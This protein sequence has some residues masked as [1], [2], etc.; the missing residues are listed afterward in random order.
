M[1]G[2]PRPPA[3]R[4]VQLLLM[5]EGHRVTRVEAAG[6]VL[7]DAPPEQCRRA[8]SKA[9]SQ[10]REVLGA[11]AIVAEGAYLRLGG[12]VGTDLDEVRGGLR[13]AL[14]MGS[15]A[16]RRRLLE[17]E[18]ERVSP[19]LPGE[20]DAD[21]VGSPRRQLGELVRAGRVAL[22]EEI[23]SASGS[24]EGWESA[25]EVDRSDEEVAV[26]LIGALRRTGADARAVQVYRACR[27]E[28]T[29]HAGA[30]PSAQLQDAVR[31]L[32]PVA[33]EPMGVGGGLL[34][35]DA[36]MKSMLGWLRGAE[37]HAGGA[38]L[39]SGLAGIGKTAILEAVSASLRQQGW[40]VGWA[41]AGAGDELVPYSALR[42]ALADVLGSAPSGV[43]VP[44]SI[45]AL[46]RTGGR[47]RSEVRWALPI[48]AADL[49][50]LLDRLAAAAPVLLVIDDVHRCDSATHD[51]VGRAVTA[52]PARSWSLLMSARTDEP[53]RAVPVLPNEVLVLGLGGLEVSVAQALARRHLESAGVA[54]ERREELATLV[55]GWSGG[56][57][58][59]LV[60]LVRHVAAGGVVSAQQIGSVPARVVELFEQRLAGCSTGARS[61]L[62]L[63]A[64]AEP[65][66]DLALVA[67]LEQTLG[68][69]RALAAGVIDELVSSAVVVWTRGRLRLSHP[70]WRQAALSRLNPLRLASLHSQ[71]ADALDRLPGR[72]LVAAG[73]RIGAFRSVPVADY[74]E[75]AARA[76]LDAGHVA[77]SLVA[78]DSALQLLAAALAA[79]EAVPASRRRK[80]RRAAFAGWMDI[81]HIRSDRLEL[82][83]AAAAFEQ[84][85]GLAGGNNEFAAGCSALGGV[86]Y[87]RGDFE[88]AE[89][90][91]ERGLRLVAG[92]SVWAQARLGADIAWA[93]HRRGDVDAALSGLAA[94]AAQFAS[95]KDKVS[96]SR[97]FDLLAVLLQAAGRLDQAFA[98]SDRA[99]AIAERCRDVRL[100]PSLAIHR[101]GLL[102][103]AGSAAQAESEARRALRAARRIGDR[104]V[105][106]V[107]QWQLADCLDAT[108]DL[109]GALACRRSEQAVLAELGNKVHL[110]RCLSH[111]ASLLHRLGRGREALD[112]A[113]RAR[114]AAADTGDAGLCELVE[115]RLAT[116]G[117][118]RVS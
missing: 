94:A 33:P 6:A 89:A 115:E 99:L 63:V 118:A 19:L 102:L 16:A 77:R 101:S 87:K 2:W 66:T 9:L 96:T 3:R 69:D 37:D 81:G 90:T 18:L 74:A 70:L 26:G 10:A 67:E 103:A 84:A 30:S 107:A 65:H 29:R 93:R 80:L 14:G 12:E 22:A 4:L 111:Q 49:A 104:Y 1:E 56:N 73:H 113:A 54:P 62:P 105:E 27:A 46:L 31:G 34:G 58:L 21:W 41:V 88:Q 71:I 47:R 25:F 72:E 78:D 24:T 86:C 91:Y 57:P 95:T 20:A 60:E 48:L 40:R 11:R 50:G 42:A 7:P 13:S 44:A 64:L 52:R 59:F 17:R 98:A 32:F 100:V 15:G 117:G 114:Q 83:A 85:L 8:V 53:G 55:G 110:S 43:G 76:G 5:A 92:R 112:H 116:M 23:E 79:F 51:L 68:L 75:A 38:V 36:E 82:D 61:T 28:L 45:R 35:R 108:G 109:Q 39:V 97:C 106:T